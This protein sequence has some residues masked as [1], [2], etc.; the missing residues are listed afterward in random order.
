MEMEEQQQQ[1][2]SPPRAQQP[3][4]KTSTLLAQLGAV[5]TVGYISCCYAI[6]VILIGLF[7]FP[8]LYKDEKASTDRNAE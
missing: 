8:F 3:T 5:N 6:T 4:S 2:Q 1:Q 7:L